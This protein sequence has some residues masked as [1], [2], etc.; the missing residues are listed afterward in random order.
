MPWLATLA[1]PA[2]GG[3]IGNLVSQPDRDKALALQQQALQNI[4]N[5]NTPDMDALKIALQHYNSAGQITP[6]METALSQG[7]SAM[8]GIST[9]PRLKNAQ[10]QAL[11][12]MQQIGQGGLRP[13]DQA[14]L[15][16]IRSGNESDERGREAS[17]MQSMQQRGQ[18][19]QGAELAAQLMSSQGA[20]N[21]AGQQGLAVGAQ[22]SQAALQ[23]I[24]NAGQLGGQL[25]SQDFS[26]QGQKAQAQD[27]INRYNTMN[28]QQVGNQNVAM[29]NAA[30]SQ[31]LANKQGI[32]NQNTGLGNQQ[33]M[34][35]RNLGQVN[36]Q[37]Q[38]TKANAQSAATNNLAN[39][40]N[41]NANAQ[42]NM[43][44]G[45][46]AGLGQAGTALYNQNQAKNTQDA[47]N[48]QNATQNANTSSY[49]D[50]LRGKQRGG[51]AAPVVQ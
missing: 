11:S 1:A 32:M 40:T 46:G 35:N 49:L 31:N 41:A 30:Q 5:V 15:A 13:E 25:R 17:I 8:A 37:N 12:R 50:I 29:Q 26:E 43:Y 47:L 16:S 51:A 18:G 21:R 36:F 9:D 33:E 19:G 3:L 4:Q 23:G 34:Y 24:M 27:V 7:P 48:T 39:A 28:S 6:Q 45:V 44:A 38:M 42:Q 2:V 20:A 10:M 22:A 14:A